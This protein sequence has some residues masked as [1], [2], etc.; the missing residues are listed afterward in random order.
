MGGI[1][2]FG[3][4]I[5]EEVLGDGAPVLLQGGL[6]AAMKQAA[7]LGFDNVEIHIRNPREFD[8]D[9]LLE[10][11]RRH[12]LTISAVGTGLEYSLNGL[13]LTSPDRDCRRRMAQRYREHIDLA[14]RLGAVVFVGLCRGKAPDFIS[15]ENYLDRFY[16]ELVP[17][18]DYAR[19]RGVVLALE[20]IVFYL[21]NLLNTTE[22]T[23]LFLERPGLEDVELLLDTHHMFIEDRSMVRSFRACRERIAHIHISD[24]NRRYPGGG[25]ID[26]DRV[27]K[28]LKEIEYDRSVSLEVLPYPSGEE[29]ARRG[30][31]WMRSIWGI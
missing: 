4:A 6:T 21:T 31:A 17:I 14:A 11:A 7:E 28:T 18:A 25:N 15:R 9:A 10:T 30:V 8:G 29:A 2:G 19:E 3:L 16:D 26:Y 27:G 5:S 23:L 1:V 12:K 22:E 20:P 13:N 24:S